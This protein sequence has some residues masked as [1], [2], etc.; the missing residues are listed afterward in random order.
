LGGG[1]G[2]LRLSTSLSYAL[3]AAV[4][5]ILMVFILSQQITAD[6]KRAENDF[7]LQKAR[8]SE[9]RKYEDAKQAREVDLEKARLAR[10]AAD[11][12]VGSKRPVAPAAI[13]K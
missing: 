5:G 13:T 1:L 12:A 7:E 8:E 4:F 11:S 6:R 3:L 9:T 2:G 10:T